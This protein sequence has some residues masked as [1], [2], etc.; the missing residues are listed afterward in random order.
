VATAIRQFYEVSTVSRALNAV[1]AVGFPWDELN[2][3]THQERV[4]M[5]EAMSGWAAGLV[6]A[7][8]V[9]PI[10]VIVPVATALF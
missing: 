2:L 4:D 6:T 1:A 3:I 5:L 9:S 8:G 10:L 7:Q